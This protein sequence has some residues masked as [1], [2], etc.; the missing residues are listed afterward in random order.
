MKISAL[1]TRAPAPP[2]AST[3]F[4]LFT[5]WQS[6]VEALGLPVEEFLAK[7]YLPP[8]IAEEN[9]ACLTTEELLRF[10]DALEAL[11][12]RES[13]VSRMRSYCRT[14]LP[15]SDLAAIASP[16][17]RS[18]LCRYAKCKR[19][20][21]PV[22]ISFES[23]SEQT[24]MTFDWLV[25]QE[26]LSHSLVILT[27]ARILDIAE[28][29][30]GQRIKPVRVTCANATE[31]PRSLVEEHFGVPL[32]KGPK[33]CLVFSNRDLERPFKTSNPMTLEVLDH[34]FEDVFPSGG[35][36][37][38]REV[39]QWLKRLLPGG[40]GHLAA[41]A[42]E[43]GCSSRQLQR[44]LTAEGT[45][46][47]SVLSE[48]RRE[49]ALHYLARGRYSPK[50]VTFLI[51]YSEPAAFH[52]AFRQWTGETPSEYSARTRSATKFPDESA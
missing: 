3:K 2:F 36:S 6:M 39:Q 15:P 41:V 37:R 30:T 1:T 27:L 11:V 26:R 45:S 5:G 44:E 32:E 4:V 14:V 18:G 47:R 24:T 29:G 49:L 38:T 51:G 52:R 21:A 9:H 43:L 35:P 28:R 7:A 22:E 17:L 12:G 19:F 10:W 50:E 25:S 23:D 46:F 20:S 16:D 33:M 48:T 31:I 42:K 8:K 34:Y 40:R 13:I